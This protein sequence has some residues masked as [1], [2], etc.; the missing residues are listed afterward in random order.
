LADGGTT[1]VEAISG[2]LMLQRAAVENVK[3]WYFTA[4][5]D[6]AG[7]VHT[8]TFHF[9]LETPEDGYDSDGYPTTRVQVDGDGAISVRTF[10]AARRARSGC[11]TASE[12]ILPSGVITGDFVELH[13]WNEIVRVDADGEI[14]WRERE[15]GAKFHAHISEAEA[16]AL[17]EKFR[18]YA[19]WSMCEHYDELGLSDGGWSAFKV[20]LDGRE[21]SVSEY[22]DAA[23]PIF[24]EVE[25]AVDA[26]A[27][28]HRWR[29]GDPQAESIIEISY[30]YF[31]KPGKT[32]LMDAAQS[33]DKAAIQAAFKA[34]E[35]MTDTDGSGWTPLM[36]AAGSSGNSGEKEML[37]AGA[38]V[39]A[40][41][42]RGETALMAAAAVGFADEALIRAGAQVNAVNDVGMTAL[43]LLTQ[44]G[45]PD[46]I[47]TM[48]KAGADERK[49]D[50]AGRTALDYLNAA[51]CGRPIVAVKDPPGMMVVSIGYPRCNALGD[52]YP[53]SK[54]LLILVGAKATRTWTPK[55]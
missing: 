45:D 18:T 53:K 32:K 15:V 14:E 40:R 37:E 51:N 27:N 38:D 2:P 46:E 5:K 13:R 42:K 48:V 39:N 54:H 43:M 9:K 21:K 1:D 29:H 17:L 35:K 22:G 49:K 25:L 44:R 12:R 11:P 36:Y 3:A 7:Q 19:V 41:S 52:D 30:E 31:P 20:R 8:A 24:G 50:A 16:N 55:K 34:G 6:D 4:A 10:K 28:T 47:A 33:G 23:P 26:V